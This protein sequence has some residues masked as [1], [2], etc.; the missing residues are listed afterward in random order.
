[1]L[2]LGVA[3]SANRETDKDVLERRAIFPTI[4]KSFYHDKVSNGLDHIKSNTYLLERLG[5]SSTDVL[6]KLIE[7]FR[8]GKVKIIGKMHDDIIVLDQSQA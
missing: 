1:M 6:G 8:V 7:S 3:I 2:M 4:G 5:A